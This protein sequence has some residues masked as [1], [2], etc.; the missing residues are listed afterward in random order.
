MLAIAVIWVGLTVLLQTSQVSSSVSVSVLPFADIAGEI[1][2]E[3]SRARAGEA[4]IVAARGDLQRS[5]NAVL[6]IVR[7]IYSVL[8]WTETFCQ[9]SRI[10]GTIQIQPRA[11]DRPL[12]Q[13]YRWR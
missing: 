10:P 11:D 6:A 5:L 1:H 9:P 4:L 7:L 3:Q 13:G 12:L 2:E 8:Q